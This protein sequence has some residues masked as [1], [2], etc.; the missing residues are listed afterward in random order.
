MFSF[1][2]LLFHC[3][4]CLWKLYSWLFRQIKIV[5]KDYGWLLL[6]KN[7][8][9][10]SH[11]VKSNSQHCNGKER[12]FWKYLCWKMS[13]CFGN[14]K[15]QWVSLKM[16]TCARKTARRCFSCLLRYQ[17]CMLQKSELNDLKVSQVSNFNLF[18]TLFS[19]RWNSSCS[20]AVN[21]KDFNFHL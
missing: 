16:D 4:E 13:L 8:P 21:T 19:G 6:K 9:L 12:K 10:E 18:Q 5:H 7:A 14:A 20:T 2:L 3:D 15:L 17:I 11:S 1:S